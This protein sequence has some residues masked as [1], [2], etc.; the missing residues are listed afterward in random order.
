[1]SEFDTN[2]LRTLLLKSDVGSQA[3]NF[4]IDSLKKN[5]TEDLTNI[6]KD[7]L[8]NILSKVDTNLHLPNDDTNV[9]LI[10]G[11]NGAGKTTSAAKLANYYK[12]QGKSVT[13]AAADTYRAGAIKQLSIWA[14]RLKVDIIT[15]Q[16]GSDPASVVWDATESAIAKKS[17]ILIIDTA[18]RLHTQKDLMSQL[19]KINKIVSKK[20]K[21][22]PHES[23]IVIDANQGQNA[24][25]QANY[26]SESINL[27]GIFLTKIDGTARGGIVFA[28]AEELNLGVKLLGVGEKPEDIE[29]FS[30]KLFVEELLS[31]I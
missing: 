6:F 8:E 23:L 5:S 7:H 9:I 29:I 31:D 16:P 22:A 21:N 25:A 13:L 14:E 4:I 20:I 30:P 12:K 10:S 17:D 15:G 11:V 28:I 26:F 2:T 1:M 27:T 19:S 18:G 24:L 3:T